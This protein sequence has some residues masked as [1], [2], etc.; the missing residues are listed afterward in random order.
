V[1]LDRLDLVEV[2]IHA[3]LMPIVTRRGAHSYRPAR[4]NRCG[5]SSVG[6]STAVRRPFD[7]MRGLVVG[8]SQSNST[9][10]NWH[11]APQSTGV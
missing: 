1:D 8:A 3:R 4:W 10:L 2:D 11:Y 6:R 7:L 9:P 5:K